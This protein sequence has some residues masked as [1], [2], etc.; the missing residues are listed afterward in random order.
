M[1]NVS[2]SQSE[3]IQET[4]A[5]TPQDAVQSALEAFGISVP[6]KQEDDPTERSEDEASPAAIQDETTP[7]AESKKLKVKFNKEDI[8]ID[9]E[10]VPEL[11]QKGL[12]LEKERQKK[13]EYEKALDRAAR[14]QGYESHEDFIAN[15]D[16]IEQE[17]QKKQED[18]YA[19]LRTEL[20]DELEANGID[21]DKAE[22]FIENH[23]LMQQAR[24]AA[25]EKK[26]IDQERQQMTVQQQAEA[27]WR[28]LYDA[29]PD[30]VESAQA[31]SQGGTPDWYTEEMNDLITAGYKPLHAYKLA[32]MDKI[33]TQ[34]KRQLEQKLVKEQRLGTRAQV[35]TDV[36]GSTEDEVPSDVASAFAAFGLPVNSAK[37]Y[38]KK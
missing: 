21:R 22:Q 1:D 5:E 31:F 10:Q 35:E 34:T 33:Q 7:Q 30:I 19:A 9:E 26:K 12:A 6:S 38:M 2:A 32:H 36:R 16:K 20:L 24:Q 11:V 17:R 4:T 13:S 8:E 37:K 28:Q 23:P 15:L 27:D 25:E 14:L 3:T 29:F 18:E